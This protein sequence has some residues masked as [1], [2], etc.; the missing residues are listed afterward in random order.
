MSTGWPE[1]LA[2]SAG[3]HG[4]FTEARRSRGFAAGVVWEEGTAAGG[5]GAAV[6]L[7]WLCEGDVIAREGAVDRVPGATYCCRCGRGVMIGASQL[8][9]AL[10]GQH[11]YHIAP[12]S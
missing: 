11:L 4:L 9:T 2:R 10:P 5:V 6:A 7:L 3:A 12:M 8:R 1:V